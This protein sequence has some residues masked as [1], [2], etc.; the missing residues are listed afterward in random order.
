MLHQK[1]TVEL[2]IG[3]RFRGRKT[4]SLSFYENIVRWASNSGSN[5]KLNIVPTQAVTLRVIPV[6]VSKEKELT[7]Q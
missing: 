4:V 3:D 7:T 2:W 1:V 5:V 6:N